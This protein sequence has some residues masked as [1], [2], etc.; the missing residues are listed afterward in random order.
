MSALPRD[1]EE[2]VQHLLPSNL[3]HDLRTPLG[4]ILGYSELLIEQMKDSGQAEQIVRVPGTMGF[5]GDGQATIKQEVGK[6]IR[7]RDREYAW[8]QAAE[9]AIAEAMTT[10]F[11]Q[12]AVPPKKQ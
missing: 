7:D 12:L 10:V 4:Q 1:I 8:D 9:V 11:K 5:T 2:K 6:T 3:L